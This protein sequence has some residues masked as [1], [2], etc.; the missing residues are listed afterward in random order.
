MTR[1]PQPE[2]AEVR[3]SAGSADPVREPASVRPGAML[4][5][6]PPGTHMRRRAPLS[7]ERRGEILFFLGVRYERR[8]S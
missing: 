2:T 3:P 5:P 7:G 4:I 6:F 1:F 8:A